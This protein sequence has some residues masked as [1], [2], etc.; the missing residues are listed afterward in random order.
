M[1]LSE[2]RE[3]TQKMDGNVEIYVDGKEFFHIEYMAE[4]FSNYPPDT[5][6]ALPHLV[7]RRIMITSFK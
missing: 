3:K 5:V 4:I 7:Q 6:F 1:T 2:F